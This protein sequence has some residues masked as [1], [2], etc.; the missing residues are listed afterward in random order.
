MD[1]LAALLDPRTRPGLSLDGHPLAWLRVPEAWD[2]GQR[3]LGE[4]LLYYLESGRI[5]LTVNDQQMIVEA[6]SVIL[7]AP[8][9]GFR[10]CAASHPG[11]AFW[12]LRLGLPVAWDGAAVRAGCEDLEPVVRALVGECGAER[13]FAAERIRGLLLALLARLARAE[14]APPAGGRRQLDGAARARLERHAAEDP[15]ATPRDLARRLDLSLDYFTRLFRATY[16][17]P[18]RAWLL[19]QRLLA[20]AVALAESAEPAA[21][22]AARLGFADPRRFSR[23]FR[24][25]FG[26]PPGR[27]RARPGG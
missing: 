25:R 8:G 17:R 9:R 26:R 22:I 1:A 15:R 6:G 5:S 4:H 21:R 11:P 18:P 3:V 7:L 27:F 19:E 12:R 24:R 20:A 2:T 14:E 23:C 16:G 13:P 10:M